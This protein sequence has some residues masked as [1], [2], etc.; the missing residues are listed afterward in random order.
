VLT[1][2]SKALFG[3]AFIIASV[4]LSSPLIYRILN[5]SLRLYNYQIAIISII[6]RFSF[7]VLSLTKHL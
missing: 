2:F 6:R 5:N 1:K 4:G 7:L 3:V